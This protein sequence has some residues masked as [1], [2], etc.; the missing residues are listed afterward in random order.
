MNVLVVSPA[1]PPHIYL[2]CRALSARGATVLGV[3]DSPPADLGADLRGA[4][5]E[6]LFLPKMAD[7]D[8][9]YRG[10]AGL[11]AR[12]GRIERLDS[13]MEHWMGVE[14]R[15]RDDFNVPG[16]RGAELTRQRSKAGMAEIYRAAGIAHPP[17]RAVESPDDLRAAAASFGLPLVLKPDTGAGAA[18][19]FAVR[20]ADELERAAARPLGGYLAQ[21]FV[22]GDIVTF[23]GLTNADGDIVFFTSH[24]YDTG[25]MQVLTGR[26]DGHYYSHREVPAELERLGR[27]AVAAFGVRERFFHAEFFRRPDGSY[28][29]L[30][31]NLRPPGGFTPDMMN[32]ACDFD[33]YDLWA[34][35]VTGERW[36]GFAY[37]RKYH[38]AHAGRRRDRAYRRSH[39]EL[40][41]ALG[42]VVVMHRPVPREFSATMGDDLYLLRHRDLGALREAIALVQAAP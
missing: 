29:A 4:L 13:L 9:L 20:T 40:A 27:R 31:M 38:V 28:V 5:A 41:R 16:L 17:G 30:E 36:P 6:Y 23:D 26:L 11:I 19:T 7:Y 35:V 33:V 14:G 21:P 2:F 12:H 10:V 15:L 25:I 1:F 22:E 8:T 37:E 18:S 39:D 32:F 34:G 24:E 3:G 42:D